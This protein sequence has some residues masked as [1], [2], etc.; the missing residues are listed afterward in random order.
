MLFVD[1]KLIL[2]IFKLSLV[3][4]STAN[5]LFGNALQNTIEKSSGGNKCD[6]ELKNTKKLLNY[7]YLIGLWPRSTAIDVKAFVDGIIQA[8]KNSLILPDVE[9]INDKEIDAAINGEDETDNIEDNI[10]AV[11]FANNDGDDEEGADDGDDGD[12]DVD[13]DATP[14]GTFNI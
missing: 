3:V 4:G 14:K 5:Q 6:W 2:L 13:D 1:L 10:D 7:S 11:L 8:I 9:D 12:V